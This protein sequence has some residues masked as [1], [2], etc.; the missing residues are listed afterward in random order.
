MP[1]SNEVRRRCRE[2]LNKEE[3]G[4][5]VSGI[6]LTD[7]E[8]QEVS[9][10]AFTGSVLVLSGGGQPA[11]EECRKWG[12][13]LARECAAKGFEFREVVFLKGLPP[14]IPKS[15]IAGKIRSESK[16]QGATPPLLDW[17]GVAE[18]ALGVADSS[19]AHIYVVDKDGVLRYRLWG[20]YSDE[21][22]EEV[23]NL[24]GSL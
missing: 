6:R 23:M 19:Q 12:A 17:N 18:K 22:L 3:V 5:N 4:A 21:A 8:G 13:A 2:M 9:L 1:D 14:F 7:V 24:A 15:F 11:M 20:K 16:A 10:S